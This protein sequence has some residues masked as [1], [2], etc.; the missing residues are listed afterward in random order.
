MQG[1]QL[2]DGVVVKSSTNID[3]VPYHDSVSTWMVGWGWGSSSCHTAM[4]LVGL[5]QTRLNEYCPVS[6]SSSPVMNVLP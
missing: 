1:T 4:G 3:T 6:V 5:S 2:L